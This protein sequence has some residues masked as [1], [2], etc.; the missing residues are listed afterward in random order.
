VFTLNI[1]E[2][3]ATGNICDVEPM[4]WLKKAMLPTNNP[5][6]RRRVEFDALSATSDC[7]TG[8]ITLHLFD[9]PVA[10]SDRT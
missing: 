4:S 5:R 10:R 7:T 1:M 9:P 3:A 2:Q 8:L 6:S